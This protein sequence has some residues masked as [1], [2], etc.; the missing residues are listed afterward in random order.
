MGNPFIQKAEEQKRE[1]MQQQL[2][3]PLSRQM[4]K[5]QIQQFLIA[6]KREETWSRAIGAIGLKPNLIKELDR[7]QI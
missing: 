5:L 6:K 4:E 2:Q 3:V 7:N 1:P